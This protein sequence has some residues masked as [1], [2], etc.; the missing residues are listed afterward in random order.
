[1]RYLSLSLL[2]WVTSALAEMPWIEPPEKSS[3]GHSVPGPDYVPT[4]PQDHGIHNPFGIEWWYWVGHLKAKQGKEEFGFQSTIF[5]VA[6]DPSP[7]TPE[8]NP[9]FGKDH[10]YLA[11]AALSDITHKRY[12]HYERLYREGWQIRAS[13][14]TLDLQV[15]GI[16]AKLDSSGTHQ[17]LTTRF[18]EGSILNLTLKPAKPIVT[19]GER[20]L[21]R[22]GSDPAA[23]SWYWSYTRLIVDGTLFHNGK[24]IP[25]SGTAWMDH[26]VSSSQ[27]GS[28]LAGW[29]WTCIQ[30][31]DGTEVKAYRLRRKDGSSDPWSSIYWIDK[32]GELSN[33]HSD[34]FTWSHDQLWK[35]PHTQLSYPTSVSITANHPTQ[36]KITY[37]LQPLLPD[38]EFLGLKE[39]NP[40]WEG[41]CKVFDASGLEIGRAYL[42]L[43]GYGGG[44]GNR[45]N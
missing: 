45:L 27:L 2:L 1:M 3:K 17:K 7:Q 29:D 25:V 38:Q 16:H 42:E 35:S 19:F 12:L 34:Q 21:S 11:H 5:R 10:M 40:Y 36:G 13:S 37:R 22:K 4:F 20:G 30:L 24:E 14:Q 28:D 31:Y 26:E 44:L 43:A 15:G 18:P 32:N 23:V 41:A 8:P 39:D 9:T 33:A 6:G